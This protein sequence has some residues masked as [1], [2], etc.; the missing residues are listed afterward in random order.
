MLTAVVEVTY[1]VIKGFWSESLQNDLGVGIHGSEVTCVYKNYNS[2]CQPLCHMWA[3]CSIL[4]SSFS[5][6]VSKVQ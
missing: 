1:M 2:P 5:I 3:G 4:S 6:E